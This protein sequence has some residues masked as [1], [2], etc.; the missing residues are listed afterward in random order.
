MRR[1]WEWFQARATSTHARAWLVALSFSES[2]FFLIPPD[3][4]LIA[5]L[6][7]RAGRWVYY[8]TLTTLASVAGALFGYYLG[9]LVFL[10]IAQ[11]LITFYGLTEAFTHVGSLYE[12]STF[13]TVLTAAVTPIPFKVFVLAGGFFSVP[14]V[15]F[16]LAS[17]VG[18]GARF[19][20]VAWIAHHYGPTSADLILKHLDRFLIAL[21]IVGGLIAAVYFFG[22]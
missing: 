5:M 18:R 3:V 2:S 20:A 17:L 21:V 8:A 16:L 14:L 22:L 12:A 1:G 11:P 15:P 13:W 4:L 19:F 10:P 6:A 9:A 7:A